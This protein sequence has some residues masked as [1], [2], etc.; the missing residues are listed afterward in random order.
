M[1]IESSA[2]KLFALIDS[3]DTKGQRGIPYC[4]LTDLECKLEAVKANAFESATHFTADLGHGPIVVNKEQFHSFLQRNPQFEH[5]QQLD[6]NIA[7]EKVWQA[8]LA[9]LPAWKHAHNDTGKQPADI[10]IFAYIAQNKA[11]VTQALNKKES[12]L[13]PLA[14]IWMFLMRTDPSLSPEKRAAL[15]SQRLDTFLTESRVSVQALG[16]RDQAIKEKVVHDALE[17]LKGKEVKP[18][19]QIR[20]ESI[21]G[22]VVEQKSWLTQPLFSIKVKQGVST[23]ETALLLRDI[24]NELHGTK[25][26]FDEATQT[27]KFGYKSTVIRALA[28]KCPKLGDLIGLGYRTIFDDFS[29]LDEVTFNLGSPEPSSTLLDQARAY[30]GNVRLPQQLPL[31][32]PTQ[33]TEQQVLS[34]SLEN[35]PGICIGERHSDASPK[36]FLIQHFPDLVAQGVTTLFME[37]LPSESLQD[38]LDAFMTSPQKS[39]VPLALSIYLDAQELGQRMTRGYSFKDVII[40]AKAAGIK[41]IICL[42]TNETYT[43]GSDLRDGV[44]DTPARVMALNFNAAKVIEAH[45]DKGKYVILVGAKHSDWYKNIPGL[46]QLTGTVS[47]FIE[48]ATTDQAVGI[49]QDQ[50]NREEEV[51]IHFD[52]VICKRKSTKQA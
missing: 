34:K 23:A 25:V 22:T 8:Q 28:E 36:H 12:P 16:L 35:R 29:S 9:E 32:L 37:H 33:C 18:Q 40:A 46:S 15:F 20:A 13:Y 30:F 44:T 19:S 47:L 27:L 11:A 21:V 7:L 17:F 38:E 49:R 26:H 10:N 39:P 45:K 3:G 41:N 24:A 4:Q 2:P 5:L 48:D 31:S 6:P 51:P 1:N 43:I 52:V 42:D 14:N 50:T